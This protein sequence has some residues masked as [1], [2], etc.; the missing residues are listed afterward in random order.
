[1]PWEGTTWWQ[2]SQPACLASAFASNANSKQAAGVC[3]GWTNSLYRQQTF[4]RIV[5]T[6]RGYYMQ[7]LLHVN[8]VWRKL[9]PPPCPLAHTLAAPAAKKLSKG[10][11]SLGPVTSALLLRSALVNW[12]ERHVHLRLQLQNSL[13]HR[14][15]NWCKQAF[16]GSCVHIRI[17]LTETAVITLT[18]TAVTAVNPQ[19][20]H[21]SKNFIRGCRHPASR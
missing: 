1:M 16:D 14:I 10:H 4:I 3:P 21:S 20:G 18:E 13:W 8:S 15:A 7:R 17:W 11:W 12:S 9:G 5:N 19:E 2:Y 6:C